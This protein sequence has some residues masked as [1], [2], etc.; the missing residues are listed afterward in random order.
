MFEKIYFISIAFTNIYGILKVQIE[1]G[2]KMIE[3]V[4]VGERKAWPFSLL[5][6]PHFN[7]N[8]Y[9]KQVS[10]SSLLILYALKEIIHIIY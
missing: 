1:V 4:S 5:L 3:L 7:H 8:F 2:E 9:F 10:P 6:N